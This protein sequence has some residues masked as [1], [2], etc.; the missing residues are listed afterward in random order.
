[1]IYVRATASLQQYIVYCDL[2]SFHS[3]SVVGVGHERHRIGRYT[4]L[5]NPNTICAAHQAGHMISASVLLYPH[6]PIHNT[7][8]DVCC[9]LLS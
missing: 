4:H 2:P 7:N 3:S 6:T 8:D 5:T 1:M 9:I